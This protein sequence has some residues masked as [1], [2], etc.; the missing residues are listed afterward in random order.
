[1]VGRLIGIIVVIII[2]VAGAWYFLAGPGAGAPAGSGTP[3]SS[4][5]PAATIAYTD[6]GFSPDSVTIA[7]GETVAWVNQSSENLWVASDPHPLHD[8][9]DGTTRS[10]HCAAGYQGPLPFDSC[11]MIK[12]GESWSFAF[13]QAGTWGYHNHADDDM[14]GSVTVLA[15]SSTEAAPMVPATT[16]SEADVSASVTL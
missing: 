15:A 7:E 5:A 3:A 16:T 8:G 2:V 6:Q 9:Y 11:T 10:E 14:R 4:A 1:M 12:P 13:T